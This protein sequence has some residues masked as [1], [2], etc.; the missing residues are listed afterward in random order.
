MSKQCLYQGATGPQC[1]CVA[2]P[3]S[4]WCET[5]DGL[6]KLATQRSRQQSEAQS[7]QE[8]DAQAMRD[9]DST[10][11]ATA[12]RQSAFDHRNDD[13]PNREQDQALARF[14]DSVASLTNTIQNFKVPD[15][16]VQPD[17]QSAPMPEAYHHRA[18][19]PR[20]TLTGL[21]PGA[22]FMTLLVIIVCVIGGVVGFLAGAIFGVI[23]AAM[24]G[25]GLW[26][27]YLCAFG[28]T[29]LLPAAIFSWA[30]WDSHYL[31]GMDP[32]SRSDEMW[33]REYRR[34]TWVWGGAMGRRWW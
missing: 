5:H 10:V 28:G 33:R 27:A 22:I 25:Q 26:L 2:K 9:L 19:A 21:P 11:H 18:R 8:A 12:R 23:L 1:A 4:L 6:V 32:Q 31:N 13:H 34:R 30:R 29:I 14:N 17:R 16:T 15:I 20:R 3:G 24:L 7:A